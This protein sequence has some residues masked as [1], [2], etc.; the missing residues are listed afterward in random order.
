MD[1]TRI[2]SLTL[3]LKCKTSPP[4]GDKEQDVHTGIRK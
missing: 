2:M 3:E 4:I 1:R